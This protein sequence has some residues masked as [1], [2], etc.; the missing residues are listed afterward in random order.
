MKKMIKVYDVTVYNVKTGKVSTVHGMTVK[1]FYMM[2]H[3]S[4]DEVVSYVEKMVP[5]KGGK[6]WKFV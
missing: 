2:V 5:D 1:G 3:A 4:A 6:S